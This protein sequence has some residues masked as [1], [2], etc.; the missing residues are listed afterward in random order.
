MY[1]EMLNIEKVLTI[2]DRSKSCLRLI[3]PEAINFSL[4]PPSE[5]MVTCMLAVKQ[6][7]PNFEGR[8]AAF[9]FASININI[10]EQRGGEA[11]AAGYSLSSF[12]TTSK[13]T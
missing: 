2:L 3:P 4:I 6:E 5:L 1:A 11:K 10:V 12:S 8:R 9:E 7:Q 13:E